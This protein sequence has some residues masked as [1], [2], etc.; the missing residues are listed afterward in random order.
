MSNTISN[1]NGSLAS[2]LLSLG[3]NPQASG[4]GSA[5][6]DNGI[7]D[8]LQLSSPS[9][10]QLEQQAAEVAMQNQN[11]VIS[12]SDE[13]LVVN[14]QAV[15]ALGQNFSQATASQGALNGGSVLSLTQ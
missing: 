3:T 12:T 5:S 1:T 2:A 6:S 10:A 7:E 8:S 4:S 13:A 9:I 15:S 11:S 14:L